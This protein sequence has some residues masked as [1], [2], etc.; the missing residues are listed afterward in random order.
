M[1]V[2]DINIDISAFHLVFAERFPIAA[3]V[4]GN[5]GKYLFAVDRE[6]PD[7]RQERGVPR[8]ILASV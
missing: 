8:I 6:A 3:P 2:V 5:D 4:H 7:H 1:M